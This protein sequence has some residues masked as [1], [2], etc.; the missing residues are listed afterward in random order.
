MLMPRTM[1]A[2]SGW[3]GK[4]LPDESIYA[5]LASD[6]KM[7]WAQKTASQIGERVN[8]ELPGIRSQVTS[9]ARKVST[10]AR[11]PLQ[12]RAGD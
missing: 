1:A 4:D 12:G 9:S 6:L 7:S 2:I 3:D 8:Y 11:R 5:A 10:L